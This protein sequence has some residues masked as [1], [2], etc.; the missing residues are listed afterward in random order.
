MD[1]VF[2]IA[3]SSALTFKMAA[4]LTMNHRIVISET[5]TRRTKYG[6]KYYCCGHCEIE[7]LHKWT[8][9]NRHRGQKWL[10]KQAKKMS[11]YVNRIGYES[12]YLSIYFPAGKTQFI[13]IDKQQKTQY[14]INVHKETAH[15]IKFTISNSENDMIKHIE[16]RLTNN[17]KIDCKIFRKQHRSSKPCQNCTKEIQRVGVKQIVYI[18]TNN[19]LKVVKTRDFTSKH[20]SSGHLEFQRNEIAM[21]AI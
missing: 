8:Q 16:S 18:D 6:S 14:Q 4:A 12:I 2:Q 15:Y 20:I 9:Q 13:H 3:E 10:K 1:K 5:N 11:L 21:A 19:E 7:C 17:R